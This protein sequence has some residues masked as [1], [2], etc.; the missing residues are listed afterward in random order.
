MAQVS[1]GRTT[2]VIAHRLQTARAAQR[3]LVVE[4]GLIVEDGS[5]HELLASGGRYAALWSANSDHHR[6]TRRHES[7]RLRE[8]GRTRGTRGEGDPVATHPELR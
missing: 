3:V 4:N 8:S 6:V 7:A 2:I 5:H 1:R